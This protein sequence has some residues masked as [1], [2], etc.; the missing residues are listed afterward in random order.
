MNAID[1][2]VLE[3]C[4]EDFRP[5]KPLA[6]TTPSGTLYRHVKRLVR[7]AWLTKEG[8]LYRTT[9]TGR[10]QLVAVATGR[11]WN[12]LERLYPPL[13]LVPTP[14]HQALVELIWAAMVA[15]QHAISPERHP[16]FVASGSTLRWKT[17]LGR[18]L[19]HAI[20]LDPAVQ[21]VDCGSEAGRSLTFRRGGDG[22]LV[23]KRALLD[24][25]FLVLDE[26][27]TADRGV[28]RTLGIFLGGRL[29]VPVE[30]DELTVRPVP[31]LTLNPR[32]A[33]TLEDRL[34]LSTPLIRRAL[35]ANL[36]A[37]PLPDLA[38]VGERA[39]EAARTHPPLVLPAP[40]T[41]IRDLH[42]AIV[43]RIRGV[44][45]PSAH[46]R[47]DVEIVANLCAGMTALI[48]EPVP[49]VAQVLHRVGIL[50]ET[51][52]WAR[53][54]WIDVVSDFGSATNSARV[55]TSGFIA[56]QR[57]P[58][59]LEK[60]AASEPVVSLAVSPPRLRPRT[61]VPELD[62]SEALRARLIWFAMETQQ[63]V[64]DALTTLL[65]LFLEWRE[66][67]ASIEMLAAILRLGE[68]LELAGV[69]VDT[70]RGFLEALE[71]LRK[72]GC[73][74]G[75]VPEARRVIGMLGMLP[76]SWTWEQAESAMQDVATVLE[77]GIELADV[78][79][80]LEQHR[81]LEALGFGEPTAVAVAEA[82][83]RAGAVGERRD[84]VLSALI[85]T[86]GSQADLDALVAEHQRLEAAVNELAATEQRWQTAVQQHRE[87]VERLKGAVARL[88]ET[89]NRLQ[90]ER[91]EAADSLAVANALRAFLMGRTAEAESLW[92][93]LDGLL[94]WRK[95]GGRADD[96]VGHIFT[97]AIHRKIL[98]FFQKL[99]QELP[100][101]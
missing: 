70:L 91:D 12:T 40:R 58:E 30:N 27:Q 71:Q 69:E 81:R 26:Y 87:H 88:S 20:G 38:T 44:L 89:Q 99:N 79:R 17:S 35:L 13:E 60:K 21:V 50:A 36:D 7:L 72:E 14:V 31:L 77:Q 76:F 3:F 78:T 11:S 80:F 64:E 85:E 49:A 42:D 86:A 84:A 73:D 48:P 95:R 101:K 100:R 63:D 5:L 41:D 6:R 62:L 34:G 98:A 18:F 61:S 65:D 9:D 28:R 45:L 47:I 25:S 16:F 24:T 75:D 4:L 83:G 54:G 96:A 52:G 19:C 2:Q 43:D 90:A 66:S 67:G 22:S 33:P 8:N 92:T 55:G 68:R 94:S 97:E 93:S 82:L 1:Q 39:I 15:R 59:T 29:V 51:F 56:Q 57:L 37:V 23:A 46:E 32:D 53:P 74:F 10:R